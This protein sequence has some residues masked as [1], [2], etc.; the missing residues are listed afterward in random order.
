MRTIVWFRGKELRIADHVPLRTAAKN[1]EV[2]P[3]FVVDPWFFD[4]V[5]AAEYPHRMQFLLDSLHALAKN[6]ESRGYAS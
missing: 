4:P 1:G 6:L 3:L 2:I 5:R